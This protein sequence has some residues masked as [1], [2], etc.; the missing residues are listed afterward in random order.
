MI[1]LESIRE[2]PADKLASVP[3]LV[4]RQNL[5]VGQTARLFVLLS[6]AAHE[7]PWV[8]VEQVTP[9]GYIGRVDQDYEPRPGH[10][11]DRDTRL[12]FTADNVIEI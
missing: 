1:E 2:V 3:P 6:G 9:N 5:R 8:E 4:E 12:E 11:L 10:R 7:F